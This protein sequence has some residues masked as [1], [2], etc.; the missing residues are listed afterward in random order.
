MRSMIWLCVMAG[1]GACM[2]EPARPAPEIGDLDGEQAVLASSPSVLI[3]ARAS[4][5]P[6]QIHQAAVVAS[7]AA[8]HGTTT[9][10][11][12]PIGG[13]FTVDCG[14]TVCGTTGCGKPDIGP[15]RVHR[16][17]PREQYQAFAVDGGTV[18]LAYH[19]TIGGLL[20]SCC[21]LDD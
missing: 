2:T 4:D 10:A 12:V 13:V 6:E 1:I 20:S 11:G 16:V 14:P 7:A 17:Q 21:I 18:C 19:P 5:G 9:C 3:S 15:P 8:C